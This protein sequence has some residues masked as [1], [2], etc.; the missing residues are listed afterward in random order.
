M[1]NKLAQLRKKYFKVRS[2]FDQKSFNDVKLYQDAH[3]PSG[4]PQF[5]L[6]S[7]FSNDGDFFVNP[8]SY[9]EDVRKAILGAQQLICITGWAVWDK[10]HLLRGEAD[11]DGLTLGEIL[12][13]KANSGV[14]V[15]VMIWSEKSSGDLNEKGVMGTHDMETFKFFKPT[16]VRGL[17]FL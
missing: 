2:Y 4:L 15:Y 13:Q 11:G 12:V 1:L 10:L 5:E 17:L 8:P 16:K 7:M 9:F 3:V 6:L 14:S